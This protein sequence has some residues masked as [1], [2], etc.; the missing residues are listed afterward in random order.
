MCSAWPTPP[1][2][3]TCPA[4]PTRMRLPTGR[5]TW[6]L[7]PPATSPCSPANRRSPTCSPRA[8]PA[9]RCRTAR[10]GVRWCAARAAR[11]CVWAW[12]MQ[13][14]APWS[15]RCH[16]STCSALSRRS[17]CP[18][19]AAAHYTPASRF[20]RP[21]SSAP[22]SPSRARACWSAP[23]CICACCWPPTSSCPR[24]TSWCRPRRP[25]PRS[26]RKVAKPVLTPRCSRF[27]VPPKPARSH[28]GEPRKPPSGSFFRW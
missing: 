21:T 5:P 2:R 16:R 10:H 17:C 4:L 28:R 25:W 11:R 3:S 14:R 18:C 9:S 24:W 26:L 6:I 15:A 23:P 27:T 22:S 13:H 20:T 8:R 7:K 12:T 1:T 19:K